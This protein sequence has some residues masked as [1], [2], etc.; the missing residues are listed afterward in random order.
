MESPIYK[1]PGQ[2]E[3]CELMK[4]AEA[5]GFSAADVSRK[6]VISK[7]SISKILAGKQT[8]RPGTIQHLRSMLDG[9]G[10]DTY[11]DMAAREEAVLYADK[12]IRLP[13]KK[14]QLAK[15]LIDQLAGDEISSSAD[16]LK[17]QKIAARTG[18]SQLVNYRAKKRRVAKTSGSK[19]TSIPESPPGSESQ[20]LPP[21]P[22]PKPH[23]SES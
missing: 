10:S 6:L 20:S 14:R 19:S 8:P 13:E 5:A 22:D 23:A 3:F 17:I 11:E 4:R 15:N 16:P 9:L 7:A 12:I 21:K 18:L 1:N 2:L